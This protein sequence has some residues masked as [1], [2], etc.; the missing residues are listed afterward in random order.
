MI[1]SAV[2]NDSDTQCVHCFQFEHTFRL[3]TDTDAT[4]SAD[5]HNALQLRTLNH[6]QSLI[7]TMQLL[8]HLI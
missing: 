1:Q 8:W 7:Y 2:I 3:Y 6:G 5:W 4:V